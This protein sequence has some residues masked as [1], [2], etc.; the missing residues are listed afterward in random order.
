MTTEEIIELLAELLDNRLFKRE[1][2]LTLACDQYHQLRE[3]VKTIEE[4]RAATAALNKGVLN[5]IISSQGY[6]LS[7]IKG[8]QS[9]LNHLVWQLNQVAR[10]DFSQRIDFLG[11]FSESFNAMCEKLE[12]QT[13]ILTTLARYDSLTKLANRQ[14]FDEHI[15]SLFEGDRKSDT[16]F[17]LML[18]DLDFFKKVN[19]TYGHDVGDIVLEQAARYLQLLF[20]TSDFLARYGGEEFIVILPYVGIDQAKLIAQRAIDYFVA[21]PI[22]IRGGLEVDITITIGIAESTKEDTSPDQVI[23]RGDDALYCAKRKGRNRYEI[24]GC[25]D[26]EA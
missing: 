20:R 4:L 5:E 7:S 9:N 25:F 24:E 18:I 17:S 19:D 8:L 10:G 23:K 14:Y 6:I 2:E 15:A 3:V 13:T 1:E 26:R 16:E 22:E 21:H 11:D 12:G